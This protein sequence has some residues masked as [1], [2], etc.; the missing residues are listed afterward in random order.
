GLT[1]AARTKPPLQRKHHTRYGAARYRNYRREGWSIATVP[2]PTSS[3]K[4]QELL[5]G[6]LDYVL[7]NGLSDLALRPLAE[8]LG[9]STFKLSYHFGSKGALV[10]AA[11]EAA[12][13]AQ[14]DEVRSWLADSDASSV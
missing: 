14:I 3:K 5:A 2:E 13:A 8:A 10:Q 9:I 1:V 4:S 12:V 6:V 7:D 11:I